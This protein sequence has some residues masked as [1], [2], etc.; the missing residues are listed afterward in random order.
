MKL[1]R[2][3]A[4]LCAIAL[5][6]IATSFVTAAPNLATTTTD[7]TAITPALTADL[8]PQSFTDVIGSTANLEVE[9][10]KSIIG[11]NQVAEKSTKNIGETTAIANSPPTAYG[12][13]VG[14]TKT[15]A[16][17]INKNTSG[18][19][20]RSARAAPNAM[21]TNNMATLNRSS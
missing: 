20:A 1:K 19:E 12:R 13:D 15:T 9:N 3:F 6:A 16:S 18:V 8:A 4:P 2:I 10:I 7:N 17:A 21:I 5:L 14:I 11:E